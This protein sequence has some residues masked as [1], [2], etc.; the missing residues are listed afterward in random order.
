MQRGR[1]NHRPDL[2]LHQKRKRHKHIIGI[3]S[4]TNCKNQIT[5][6]FL[7]ILI[8]YHLCTYVESINNNI[9]AIFILLFVITDQVKSQVKSQESSQKQMPQLLVPCGMSHLLWL[10]HNLQR[11]RS[12]YFIIYLVVRMVW[13]TFSHVCLFDRGGGG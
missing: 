5:H 8:A 11:D 12:L 7:A 2:I 9:I 4:Q 6:I 1:V 3:T 13:G 10:S